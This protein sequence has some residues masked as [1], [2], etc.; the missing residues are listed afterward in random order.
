MRRCELN[1]TNPP[2]QI[3]NSE[4]LDT[5]SYK[6]VKT[7]GDY[8]DNTI[9]HEAMLDFMANKKKLTFDEFL[10]SCAKREDG[11]YPYGYDPSRP[12]DFMVLGTTP[13][14]LERVWKAAQENV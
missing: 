4:E 14:I 2:G 8:I 3:D 10:L 7:L 12:R 13:Q 1:T 11:T 5:L 6:P 9:K